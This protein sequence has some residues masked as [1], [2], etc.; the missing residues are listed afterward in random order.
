[1]GGLLLLGLG[2]VAYIIYR[3]GK[4]TGSRKGYYCRPQTP[5]ERSKHRS[6]TAA[7][8]FE[9]RSRPPEG[10][11]SLWRAGVHFFT[12]RVDKPKTFVRQFLDVAFGHLP[13]PLLIA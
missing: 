8:N 5:V 6:V 10:Q 2:Y 7:I 9:I 13:I 11:K 12:I 4:R 1:M 3:S